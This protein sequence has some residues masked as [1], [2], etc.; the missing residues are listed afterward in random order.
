MNLTNLSDLKKPVCFGAGL[1]ALD[2]ILNGSPATLPKLSAGGSC[3]NVLAILAYLG[4]MSSPIARLSNDRA[5]FELIRDLERWHIDTTH[6]SQDETGRTPIIIH[7]IK[8]DKF[9]EPV[10]RFEFRDPETGSWLPQFRA[11]TKNVALEVLQKNTVPRVFYFDRP[12]PATFELARNLRKQ[13]SIICFEP[14]SIKNK[15]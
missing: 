15:A 3:G 6:L 5:G 14:S 9:G 4:W 13:G 2:V 10:H 11:I 1:V 7:R 12:N 8:R